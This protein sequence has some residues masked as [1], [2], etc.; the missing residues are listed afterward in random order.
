M[1]PQCWNE[2]A[3]VLSVGK[4]KRNLLSS[5][6]LQEALDHKG[7]AISSFFSCLVA[8]VYVAFAPGAGYLAATHSQGENV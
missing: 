2:A 1:A 8:G 6:L 5:V 7:G 4:K 3:I